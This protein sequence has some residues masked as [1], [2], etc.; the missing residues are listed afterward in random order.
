MEISD[1]LCFTS[2][3]SQYLLLH[4]CILIHKALFQ[5]PY[6]LQVSGF[7]Q[8][9]LV[10]DFNSGAM[11]SFSNALETMHQKLRLF[12]NIW[13]P[14]YQ[15]LSGL[16]STGTFSWSLVGHHASGHD[17]N[18]CDTPC[19]LLSM[20]QF[21]DEFSWD[22][23][24]THSHKNKLWCWKSSEHL[25]QTEMT[26]HWE[27][28]M[29]NLTDE[30]FQWQT[31]HMLFGHL[32]IP[33]DFHNRWL[34]VAEKGLQLLPVFKKHWDD[35]FNIH[36]TQ[37]GW[38]DLECFNIFGICE[39]FCCISYPMEDL[40][41]HEFGDR[42]SLCFSNECHDGQIARPDCWYCHLGMHSMRCI[43]ICTAHWNWKTYFVHEKEWPWIV[44]ECTTKSGCIL[45]PP[46][47]VFFSFF[48][49]VSH[50]HLFEWT[51]ELV[52][53]MGLCW[54]TDFQT[55]IF[56]APHDKLTQCDDA[57]I[58]KP[59]SDVFHGILD[60]FLGQL[61]WCFC[62]CCSA[63]FMMFCNMLIAKWNSP[64]IPAMLSPFCFFQTMMLS[65]HHWFWHA[66]VDFSPFFILT[67][68]K[69]NHTTIKKHFQA[70]PPKWWS[71]C[72]HVVSLCND[73][74]SSLHGDGKCWRTVKSL[75]HMEHSAIEATCLEGAHFPQKHIL[76]L[77]QF[78]QKWGKSLTIKATCVFNPLFPPSD[79]FTQSPLFPQKCE[80]HPPSSQFV[81]PS[82]VILST[83]PWICEIEWS[84]VTWGQVA[85][86]LR[87][88]AKGYRHRHRSQTTR[89]TVCT[90]RTS[91]T[92]I[93][94]FPQWWTWKTTIFIN[95]NLQ[96][97]VPKYS[98]SDVQG[99]TSN[100]KRNLSSRWM[101][102]QTSSS[103]TCLQAKTRSNQ[104]F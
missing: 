54:S 33:F 48:S 83:F 9:L 97:L 71:G 8:S 85:Q 34:I 64:T 20:C 13:T 86:G 82:S 57:I 23:H 104:R 59:V 38:V 68:A 11:T 89:C 61:H 16:F 51:I 78:N 28:Q 36:M 44:K 6:H 58:L 41:N 15:F 4:D 19:M 18:K 42:I 91:R 47:V 43:T 22:A 49:L 27:Q 80:M 50:C 60:H 53:G 17:S 52:K 62:C 96:H 31:V 76:H 7:F 35:G 75:I 95:Q 32:L 87:L 103:V 99:H 81:Q 24:T 101:K 100:T 26:T 40:P 3:R 21:W 12:I 29:H 5:Q 56:I 39:L 45:I 92:H 72:S 46:Q 25:G 30:P 14:S 65:I 1:C 90:P 2:I 70:I 102:L 10:F 37:D 74:R 77:F 69:H 98:S 88:F 66:S 94:S 63:L 84:P 79:F 67:Q 93:C 55:Q 73:I